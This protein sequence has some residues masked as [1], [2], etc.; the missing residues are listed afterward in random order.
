M[1]RL[2]LATS[3]QT[4]GALTILDMFIKQAETDSDLWFFLTSVKIESVQDN[5][6][7]IVSPWIKKNVITKIFFKYFFLKKIIKKIKPDELLS[8]N[9]YVLSKSRVFQVLYLHQAL[10]FSSYRPSITDFKLNYI[11]Y[12]LGF[13]IKKSLLKADKIIVQTEWFKS[14]LNESCSIEKDK[15]SVLRPTISN[16]LINSKP[17]S[18]LE[19]N[20]Y[21]YPSGPLS[22]KNHEI[23]LDALDMLS[24]KELSKIKIY[25]TLESRENTYSK[26]LKKRVDSMNHPVFFVGYLQKP[27]L[28]QYYSQCKLLYPSLIESFGLPIVEAMPYKNP[29][30]AMDLPY[31]TE[32]LNNYDGASYFKNKY[33]LAKILSD[34]L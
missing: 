20:C 30:I 22:Y 3:A 34:Y 24:E 5:V 9:N 1:K 8:L 16:D 21:I 6:R 13:F 7:F 12:F 10:P 17:S 18:L 28:H 11:K 32:L 27:I 19:G 15:I 25:F 26:K 33:E 29:I 2:V 31:S 23:I 4:G 14:V